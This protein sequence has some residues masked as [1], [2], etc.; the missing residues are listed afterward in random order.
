MSAEHHAR[1]LQAALHGPLG[2]PEAMKMGP[3]GSWGPPEQAAP[4]TTGGPT[5]RIFEAA[6]AHAPQRHP[7]TMKIGA[8][9]KGTP[10]Q[11]AGHS[12]FSCYVAKGGR[13]TVR[14]WLMPFVGPQR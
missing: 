2:H 7:E 12:C 4:A 10:P 13:S 11:P 8:T 9:A 1:V 5:G 3:A 14:M 6:V